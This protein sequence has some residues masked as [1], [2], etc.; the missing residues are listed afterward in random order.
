MSVVKPMPVALTS[1]LCPVASL[2]IFMEG[3][4][5]SE[6]PCELLG[7]PFLDMI[8][9]RIMI[10]YTNKRVNINTAPM[11]CT[12]QEDP[13]RGKMFPAIQ[14]AC[15]VAHKKIGLHILVISPHMSSVRSVHVYSV[16]SV[17]A[18]RESHFLQQSWGWGVSVSACG[19]A[20][21]L[22]WSPQMFSFKASVC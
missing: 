6:G 16:P 1:F 21:G 19:Y 18:S 9:S 8:P 12:G 20:G 3:F 2:N 10:H 17:P 15:S 11:Q 7:E 4:L 14:M 22:W 13:G 5:T